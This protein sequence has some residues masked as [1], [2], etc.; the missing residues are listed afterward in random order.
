MSSSKTGFPSS[1]VLE[2]L[3]NLLSTLSLS[4]TQMLGRRRSESG[5]GEQR[6]GCTDRHCPKRQQGNL[7]VHPCLRCLVGQRAGEGWRE[8]KKKKNIV[9]KQQLNASLI[10][11][12]MRAARCSTSFMLC[13]FHRGINTMLSQHPAQPHQPGCTASTADYLILCLLTR[14]SLLANLHPRVGTGLLGDIRNPLSVI[15]EVPRSQAKCAS[16][17]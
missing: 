8:K 6:A 11:L 5:D 3:P 13:W 10:L 14:L 2:A 12:W 9:I 4:L 17:F 7:V 15:L 1:T 16:K